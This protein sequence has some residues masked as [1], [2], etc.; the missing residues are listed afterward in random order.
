VKE[1]LANWPASKPLRLI[2]YL[3]SKLRSLPD[4]IPLI[5]ENTPKEGSCLDLFAGTT[6]VGQALLNYCSVLSNDCL[7]FAKIFS[8]VLISGPPS[9]T[10]IPLPDLSVLH[11]S[12]AY[13]RN[14]EFLTE[15]YQAALKEEKRVLASNDEAGLG[16]LARELP[17]S[18][19][20]EASSRAHKRAKAFLR[21]CDLSTKRLDRFSEP[22]YLFTAYYAGN[23][24]GISQAI[25]I[26][27]LRLA[28]EAYRQQGYI[29]EWQA[30]ALLAGLLA[31]CSRAVS[32][33]GKHFAQPLILNSHQ[34][35]SFALRR[36]LADRK[37]S[38]A[39]EVGQALLRIGERA[40]LPRKPSWSFLVS[41]ED[42]MAQAATTSNVLAFERLFGVKGV[43]TLY[44]DPPY[45]AQQYSRFYHILETLLLY[46]YPDLQMHPLSPSTLTQGLYRL[47]RH[48]SVFC[49]KSGAP[50]A[51][52]ALFS[53]AQQT[54]DSLIL[55]YSE[56]TTTS[57]NP[58]MI[59]SATILNLAKGR[60]RRIEEQEFNHK[61]RKLNRE[62]VNRERG[63]PEKLYIFRFR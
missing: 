22:A 24:F 38:I 53:I 55:S 19:N 45:T 2:H 13:R 28:I 10:D 46:D 7:P 51:F 15:T 48:K 4:I 16:H 61:Y 60:V 52:E 30:K 14:I 9:H 1:S 20:I 37:V 6:V 44:A 49:S 42:I 17:H 12:P 5:E 18:W 31:S 35:R 56:T 58:R 50:K 59:D 36:G 43:D 11:G 3:G 34:Q 32:T 40:I 57:G 21:K 33:A 41:F 23:Y 26:D 39:E 8:D 29:S 25:E 62:A 63:D 54:S 47:G 27:S